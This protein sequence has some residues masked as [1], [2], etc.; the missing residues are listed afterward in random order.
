MTWRNRMRLTLGV[1]VVILFS[2]ALLL[3]FNHRQ[4]QVASYQATV[5]ADV[6]NV[7]ADHS[8]TVI[9]QAVKVGDKVTKG[10]LLFEVQSI[11][12]KEDLANGL[13][14][15][16]TL[17]YTVDARRGVISYFAV[18][19]GRVEQLNAQQGNSVPAG[20]SL[21]TI[22]GSERFLIGDFH[23]AP[24]DYARVVPG[25]Q[26]RATLPNDQVISATVDKVSVASSDTG[27]VTS[28]KLASPALA[29]LDQPTLAEP[30]T[31]V[32]VT[33]QLIDSGPLSGLTDAV[34]DLLQQVGLR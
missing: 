33:V 12:L 34:N 11:Q 28:L 18:T 17:A 4:N 23:L 19:D 32:I 31:P 10:E 8:G 21:A 26:A 30:G 9:K 22:S 20:G 5:G 3:V 24:R 2:F 13:V 15:S 16:D 29:S 6:Y 14:V 7:G 1:L 25:A 27:A